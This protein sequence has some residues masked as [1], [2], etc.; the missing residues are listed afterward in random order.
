MGYPAPPHELAAYDSCSG[1][2]HGC[3]AVAT[4]CGRITP[5]SYSCCFYA[6]T[7]SNYGLITP[8]RTTSAHVPAQLP[9]LPAPR[10]TDKITKPATP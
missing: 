8:L 2:N 3:G 7:L 5:N 6:V 1:C 9:S 10:E 4:A